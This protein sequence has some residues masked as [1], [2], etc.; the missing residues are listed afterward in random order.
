MKA[1]KLSNVG[2]MYGTVEGRRISGSIEKYDDQD[3]DHEVRM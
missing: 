2:V 3:A 1:I